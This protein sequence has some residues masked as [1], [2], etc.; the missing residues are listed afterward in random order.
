MLGIK[1]TASSE[2]VRHAY[3]LMAKK[4]HP[5]R[6]QDPE[7]QKAAQEKM[8]ELNKAYQEAL[9]LTTARATSPYMQE[10]SCEDS[11]QLSAK[12]LRQQHP[13]SALREL[14]RASTKNAAWYNQQGLVLM[15][16]EQYESAH[17]SFREAVRREPSNNVYRRGALEAAV[18]LKE[19]QT[20]AGK[21]RKLLHIKK[22]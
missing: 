5:D 6:F 7:Q 16:M 1:P 12:M 22:H 8:T 2:E 10:I 3:H 13:E 21:V 4:Y 20:L 11:I 19:S 17:Q 15:A 14:M 9:R 18:A